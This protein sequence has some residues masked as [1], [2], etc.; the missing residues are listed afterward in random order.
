[1]IES[2]GTCYTSPTS[3][4]SLPQ[5]YFTDE[6]V[7][8]RDIA[9][10]RHHLW[11]LVGHESQIPN[12]GDY[13]LYVNDRDSVIIIRDD[14][15]HVRAHY[16]VCRHR[17]ARI[18]DAAAG[19]LRL[20]VCPYH[21]WT[22]ELDGRLR[23]APSTQTIIEKAVHGLVGCQVR[24]HCG[25]IFLSFEP[26]PPDFESY[27]SLLTREFEL[28]DIQHAKVAK[29]LVFSVSANWKLLVQNNL[30]C[31]HCRP[32]HPTYWAA[33]PGTLTGSSEEYQT[34]VRYS[35]VIAALGNSESERSRNFQPFFSASRHFQVLDRR[36][37]GGGHVTESVGGTPVAPLMGS[38]TFDGIQTLAAPSPLTSLAMNPDH[39]VVFNFVPRATRC[40]DVE[41][42]WLVKATAREGTDY[43]LSKVVA[44]WEPTLR[45]DGALAERTQ[46]GVESTGYRPG[47]Y[48]INETA[49]AEF[50]AWYFRHILPSL[51]KSTD[52]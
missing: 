19:N 13:L 17:G 20:L 49:V 38:S 29:R 24:V 8:R 1:M 2:H 9:G 52:T 18:C 51:P 34:Q 11:F 37:I 14:S 46:S 44:V 50:D 26:D 48:T 23:A 27:V 30:E 36:V 16:N 4:W 33:H 42:L 45:E 28:H 31:Y 40:T 39:V 3:G 6:E 43:D 47:P 10:L 5:R 15:E 21:A 22:Y 7:Y 12:P 41:V 35:R 32:A 25:L